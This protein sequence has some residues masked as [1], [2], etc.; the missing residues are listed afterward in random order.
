MLK[1]IVSRAGYGKTTY[2]QQRIKELVNDNKEAVLIIPEQISFESERDILKT[3]G[4]NK[5]QKVSV[6]SFTRLCSL[7]FDYFGGREKPYI[8]AVGK[9]ALMEQTLKNLMPSLTLFK[10]SAT[11]SQF[12][13]M[14]IELDSNCKKNSVDTEM[15]QLA[16]EKSG[17]ILKQK[18]FESSLILSQYQNELNKDYF[19]PL[20]D[21]SFVT[22]KVSSSD[23]FTGKTVFIDSFTGFTLQQLELIK[24]IIKLADDT[25]ISFD[26]I[27]GYIKNDYSLFSNVSKIVRELKDYAAQI[28]VK[29]GKDE[30]FLEN[31]RAENDEL[32]FLEANIFVNEQNEI[33][34]EP[35]NIFL[36]KTKNIYEEAEYVAKTILSLVRNENLRFREISVISR[37]ANEYNGIIDEV[38]EKY[39]IPLFV[40]NRETVENFS[41]FKLVSYSLSAV[42][43]SFD[44]DSVMSV[45]QTGILGVLDEEASLFEM[46]CIAWRI[47][48]KAFLEKFD[49][50]VDSF[51]SGDKDYKDNAKKTIERVRQK[52]ITPLQEFQKYAGK[53]AKSICHAIFNLIT[54]YDCGKNLKKKAEFLE[55]KGY[56]RLAE[57]TARS[58]DILIHIL[59]Q[60]YLSLS[61]REVDLKRFYE[62]FTSITKTLD[63]GSLPQGLDAVAVGSAERM[64]PKSPKVTFIIGANEGVFPSAKSGSGLFSDDELK[65]LK[66]DG[67]NLPFYDIDTAV[68]EQ[69]LAYLALCSPSEKLYVSYVTSSLSGEGAESSVIVDEIKKLFKGIQEKEFDNSEIVCINDALK[70]YAKSKG[71]QKEIEKYFSEHFDERFERIKNSIEEGEKSLTKETATSLYGKDIYASASKIETYNKCHFSYFCKYGLKLSTLKEIK[72]DKLQK[73]N[74]IH[75]VFQKMIEKYSVE[76]FFKLKKEELEAQVDIFFEECLKDIVA[77]KEQSPIEKYDYKKT[78]ELLVELLGYVYK[79]LEQSYFTPVATELKI[80]DE[81]A[82]INALKVNYGEGNVVLTGK[83]DR[84]DV[85]E[86]EG[87]KYLRIIDYKSSPKDLNLSEIFAGQKLQMPLYMKAIIEN[88]KQ[89]FGECLPAGMFYFPANEAEVD[90]GKAKNEEE[91]A[92]ELQKKHKLC[93]M[94]LDESGAYVSIEPEGKGIYSPVKINSGELKSTSI[95]SQKQFDILSKYIEHLLV[96]N[97]NEILNGDITVNPKKEACTFC[98]YYDICKFKGELADIEKLESTEAF[99]KMLEAVETKGGEQ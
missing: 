4:A 15:L 26:C 71:N 88:G 84:V 24:K 91:K 47:S 1:L 85:A 16:S 98:D 51:L 27:P 46:Y 90:S 23:F 58:Y 56:I 80:D 76:E 97:A 52:V 28:G 7:F 63:I 54:S 60:L 37:D 92:I 44:F 43:N 99:Q 20:D 67:I 86:N 18:L 19:D 25:Y 55:Q 57:N 40:D 34:D 48:G 36:T 10:K 89:K 83:V 69:Y 65:T 78:K 9:T 33:L 81:N 79:D 62:I 75:F 73:G 35:E 31:K 68:D 11:S 22:N 82:D 14:M 49:L 45:L 42:N 96:K 13:E 32:R 77:N 5:L 93:G 50:P 74:I 95:Y 94:F 21:L 72:V 29:V 2:I 64:R 41:L 61:E 70:L 87:K 30:E 12:C 39:N 3:V 53:N 66:T 38:F 6:M 17:G 8:D 59:D